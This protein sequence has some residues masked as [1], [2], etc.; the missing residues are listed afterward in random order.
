MTTPPPGTYALP[1]GAISHYHPFPQLAD[2]DN[3][4]ACDAR[5]AGVRSTVQWFPPMAAPGEV[6]PR[7]GATAFFLQ[8]CGHRLRPDRY[9]VFYVINAAP[10]PTVRYPGTPRQEPRRL[11]EG[12]DVEPMA[13]LEEIQQMVCDNQGDGDQSPLTE[14]E[15]WDWQL[16]V[17]GW[18]DCARH[19]L[20]EQGVQWDPD[21]GHITPALHMTVPQAR[22]A[23]TQ[24]RSRRDDWLLNVV[25]D[26][27]RQGRPT[28]STPSRSSGSAWVLPL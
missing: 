23:W 16:I 12:D 21:T 20:D 26:G 19:R 4:P 13:D 14:G 5:V 15:T 22:A 2:V 24:V 6:K 28:D 25:I 18:A 7:A 8:P 1:D 3:C 17:F 11:S 10:N 9:G 27:T